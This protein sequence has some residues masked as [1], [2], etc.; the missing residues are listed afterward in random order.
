[1]AYNLEVGRSSKYTGILLLILSTSQ[2]MGIGICV[3]ALT[4]LII[5]VEIH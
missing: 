1:M 3:I 5:F 2:S 4:F